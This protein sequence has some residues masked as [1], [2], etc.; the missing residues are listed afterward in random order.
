[1]PKVERKTAMI[2]ARTEPALKAEA[3]A[4]LEKLGLSPSTAINLF[5]RQIVEH[6]GL[7]FQ[8][9]LPNVTTRRAMRDA[10]SG[11]DLTHGES[12]DDL[13]SDIDAAEE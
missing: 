13:I 7:P 12:V 10:E 3:E 11:R 4:T 6:R 1:V 8:V 2:R 5:Y 9:R